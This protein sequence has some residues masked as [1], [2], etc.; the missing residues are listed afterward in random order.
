MKTMVAFEHTYHPFCPTV[1]PSD[2]G[3]CGKG[4]VR[5]RMVDG[6][7]ASI[8]MCLSQ[9]DTSLKSKLLGTMEILS[10]M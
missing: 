7:H 8:R 3:E 5:G 2:N 9:E 1:C 4:R 6:L 10:G